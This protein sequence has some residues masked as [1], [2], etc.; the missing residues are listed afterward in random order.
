MAYPPADAAV[1]EIAHDF[2]NL[3][4][5]ILGNASLLEDRVQ[6]VSEKELVD[7]II[8]AS[9]RGAALVR[10]ILVRT[11]QRE[12]ALDPAPLNDTIRST[13]RQL[14]P[15][16]G[17]DI[18]VEVDLSE[19]VDDV[20]IGRSDLERSISNLLLN[21]REAMADGGRIRIETR[22]ERITKASTDQPGQR[23]GS[24]A[25]VTISDSGCGMSP[26]IRER[27]F[28][29]FYST[30]SGEGR[31][32]GLAVVFGLAKEAGGYIAVESR[33]GHGS[34]FRLYLPTSPAA[35]TGEIRRANQ[36]G[37]P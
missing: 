32:L 2:N 28:E 22:A 3:L 23:P 27:I 18:D 1:A 20:G 21:A 12:F 16:I 17:P 13:V 34:T 4:S 9:S 7:E 11:Q 6:D 26:L 5:V 19:A 37:P 31:G 35:L 33:E 15:I 25:L 30:K 10:Q 24:Y 29:S 8:K 14:D 36:P